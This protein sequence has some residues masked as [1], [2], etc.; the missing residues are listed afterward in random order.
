MPFFRVWGG[1]AQTYKKT[2]CGFPDPPGSFARMLHSLPRAGIE[3]G[4][5][6]CRMAPLPLSQPVA[7]PMCVPWPNRMISWAWNVQDGTLLT[8]PK[9]SQ[10]GSLKWQE[11]VGRW[12]PLNQMWE[13]TFCKWVIKWKTRGWGTNL[14]WDHPVGSTVFPQDFLFKHFKCRWI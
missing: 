10:T 8:L 9:F 1:R 6:G 7:L 13:E 4:L 12:I 2:F 14:D 5:G 3:C 11:C